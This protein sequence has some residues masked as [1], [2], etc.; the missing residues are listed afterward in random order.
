MLPNG[1]KIEKSTWDSPGWLRKSTPKTNTDVNCVC[2]CV[3]VSSSSIYFY[4]KDQKAGW[5]WLTVLL[6]VELDSHPQDVPFNLSRKQTDRS[7]WLVQARCPPP[8]GRRHPGSD[9]HLHWPQGSPA[10]ATGRPLA[11]RGLSSASGTRRRHSKLPHP[12]TSPPESRGAHPEQSSTVRALAPGSVP[13][14]LHVRAEP[15]SG[16]CVSHKNK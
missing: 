10:M 8:P 13:A 9:G 7:R 11:M 15:R 3:C 6:G 12:N 16:L 2:V 4:D 5:C 14:P 1:Q